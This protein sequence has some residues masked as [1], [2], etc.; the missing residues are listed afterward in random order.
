MGNPYRRRSRRR[1]MQYPFIHTWSRDI[2]QTDRGEFILR[3]KSDRF[4]DVG[5]VTVY[6]QKIAEA[7]VISRAICNALEER[8]NTSKKRPLPEAIQDA[9]SL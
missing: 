3:I 4:P 2:S 1:I 5:T 7:I 8:H 6:T 9:F